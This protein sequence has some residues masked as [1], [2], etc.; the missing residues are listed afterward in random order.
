MYL[1]LKLV[2]VA[3][4]VMFLGNI[5]VGIFWKR[6]ADGTGN[7]AMMAHAI[8]GII[9]ADKIFTIPG[10]LILLI[11]GIGAAIVG[12]YPI[13]G[14]GWI[15]WALIAFILSGL[16]FGP[17]SRTQRRLSLAAH[18][19]NLVDYESLSR[20]WDLW[21]FIA[22]ALPVVA[23]VLMILKPALPAFGH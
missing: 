16:A 22:L 10:I 11:G 2:H 6:Y 18:T 19:G 15:L 14:T 12:G 9:K 17:L 7:A 21:G 13:L 23:F 8:D 20:S 5:A 1:A 3:G 4:V